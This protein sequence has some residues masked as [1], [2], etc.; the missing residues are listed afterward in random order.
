MWSGLVASYGC[1]SAAAAL[2]L[3]PTTALRCR[4]TRSVC[5]N[6][7]KLERG[8]QVLEL[9]DRKT[10]KQQAALEQFHMGG[11]A[12]QE[13]CPHTYKDVCRAVNASQYACNRLHKR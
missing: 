5:C 3:T 13:P 2:A 1:P 6:R 11:A 9:L 4:A 7:E 10:A 12:V 8:E